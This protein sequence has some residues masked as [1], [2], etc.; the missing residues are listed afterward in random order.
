M[1]EGHR[2]RL[3][4]L[5]FEHGIGALNDYQVL[6]LLLSFSIPRKDTNP[7]AHQLLERYGTLTRVFEA[8]RL[9]LADVPGVGENSA[10]LIKLVGDVTRLIHMKRSGGVRL[11]T[12]A[13]RARYCITLLASHPYEAMYLISLN[14]NKS[15]LHADKISSGTLSETVIYP[16]IAVECALRH[17]AYSVILT[18]N[19]PSGNITPSRDDILTTQRI[20]EALEPIGIGLEDHIITGRDRAYS[21]YNAFELTSADLGKEETLAAEAP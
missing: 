12:L 6:E 7:L 11:R 2:S 4:D 10:A 18:H 14:K 3:R 8:E 15:F 9:D 5:Y 13:D 16:R 1:H 17:H 21:I 20:K 19:H